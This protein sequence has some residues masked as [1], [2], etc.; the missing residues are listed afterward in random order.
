MTEGMNIIFETDSLHYVSPSIYHNCSIILFKKKT[1][2]WYNIYCS[3]INELKVIL[4]TD[5]IETIQ[6][7]IEWLVPAVLNF[8]KTNIEFT[9]QLPENYL[10]YVSL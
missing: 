1:I 8:L 9:F 3:F 10:F 2:D 5:Q 6:N 4:L 7:I